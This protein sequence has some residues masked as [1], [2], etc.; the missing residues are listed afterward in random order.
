MQ[1]GDGSFITFTCFEGFDG[2]LSFTSM[3]SGSV[4]VDTDNAQLDGSVEVDADAGKA[5]GKL[6]LSLDGAGSIG[7]GLS[8]SLGGGKAEGKVDVSADGE[9]KAEAEVKQSGGFF[10]IFG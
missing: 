7:G 6:S 10:G 5:S 9:T 8:L 4:D 1:V 3:V 2:S